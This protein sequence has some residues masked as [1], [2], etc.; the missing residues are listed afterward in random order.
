M[1]FG[2]GGVVFCKS[3]DVKIGM[4]PVCMIPEEK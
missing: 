1:C 2:T 4:M 3:R